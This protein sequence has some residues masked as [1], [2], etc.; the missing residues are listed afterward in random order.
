MMIVRTT[1]EFEPGDRVYTR[2]DFHA[3]DSAKNRRY[4]TVVRYKSGGTYLVVPD[5]MQTWLW[6]PEGSL[7]LV[8]K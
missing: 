8:E 3:S 2:Y 6:V 5:D 1:V 7:W 4:G